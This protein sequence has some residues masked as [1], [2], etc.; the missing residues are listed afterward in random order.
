[1]VC[2]SVD[3]KS[4][5]W[6]YRFISIWI[7]QKLCQKFSHFRRYSLTWSRQEIFQRNGCAFNFN[8][9]SSSSSYCSSVL[10]NIDARF[11]GGG[12]LWIIDHRGLCGLIHFILVWYV[13][14]G[15]WFFHWL[16]ISFYGS[17]W[18]FFWSQEAKKDNLLFQFHI[19]KKMPTIW[20]VSYPSVS[21]INV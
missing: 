19:N 15:V 7:T 16:V 3:P 13:H 10:V 20:I 18:D 5:V 6:H 4:I 14:H 12:L 8:I 21:C 11:G 17:C 2:S 9:K 1:M